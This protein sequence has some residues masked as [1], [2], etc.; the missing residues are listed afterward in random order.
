MWVQK[1]SPI[2]DLLYYTN[3]LVCSTS[4]SAV[5]LSNALSIPS[6]LKFQT[7]FYTFKRLFF[8]MLRWVWE[9]NESEDDVIKHRANALSHHL[10]SH[11]L[12]KP[13]LFSHY[14]L[15]FTSIW[16][17]TFFF[18]LIYLFIEFFN[19]STYMYIYNLTRMKI[20]IFIPFLLSLSERADWPRG[21]RLAS[22]LEG[23]GSNP[24]T[25]NFLTNTKG[26]V[27]PVPRLGTVCLQSFMIKPCLCCLSKSIW[28]LFCFE[29]NDLSCSLC[30]LLFI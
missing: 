5:L 26:S 3:Q 2:Y 22:E 6:G 7:D 8:G 4:S 1:P 18:I 15:D 28:K 21:Q 10:R 13:I 12:L 23:P 25:T 27:S 29:L 17:L 9:E 24:E 16:K 19:I 11:S 20:W 14:L 30:S